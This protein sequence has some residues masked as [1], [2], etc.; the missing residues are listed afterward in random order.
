VLTRT[1]KLPAD[2]SI[3]TIGRGK[4]KIEV[5]MDVRLEDRVIIVTGAA[6]GVGRAV[7][8]H[9]A[10]AGAGALLLTDMNEAG[11]HDVADALKDKT[12]IEICVAELSHIRAATK[13]TARAV[14][15]F[16]KID[17]LV[18]AAALTTRGSFTDGTAALWDSLFAVNARAPFLL[19]QAAI[20]DMLSRGE[21]G[22]IV[23]IQ[24]VNAHCGGPDLAIYSATKGALQTLTKNAANTYLKDRIRVNGI[25]LGWTLTP[26]EH[27]LQTEGLGNDDDWADQ[28]GR[29]LPLGRLL[30]P[31]DAARATVYLL[32]DAS[33]PMTGLS[34]ELE[35]AVVGAPG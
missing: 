6:S 23:N 11:L 27:K 33:L 2:C 3:T 18:N 25:N 35:Q 5:I 12:N 20:V 29:Q 34:V 19:M 16:G 10:D 24:S 7:A 21:G 13:I 28:A 8:E 31:G 30:A 22:A 15:E 14:A 9:A 1:D 4:R 17:G 26:S 32:S